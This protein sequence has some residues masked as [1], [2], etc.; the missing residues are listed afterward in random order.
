M[1]NFSINKKLIKDTFWN[2]QS[3]FTPSLIQIIPSILIRKILSPAVYG[4]IAFFDTIA[5]FITFP[6]SILRSGLERGVPE[7][8]RNN[9]YEEA[10]ILQKNAFSLSCILSIFIFATTSI[11]GYLNLHIW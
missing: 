10:L 9:N 2:L 11:I 5:Y 4:Y 3:N 7:N 6:G 1:S 8:K